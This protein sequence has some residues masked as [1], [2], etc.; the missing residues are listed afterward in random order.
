[1]R[2]TAK[3]WVELGFASNAEAFEALERDADSFY[4]MLTEVYKSGK[5]VPLPWKRYCQGEQDE[6]TA[7]QAV[8]NCLKSNSGRR[9]VPQ[10]NLSEFVSAEDQ[11]KIEDTKKKLARLQEV[12]LKAAKERKEKADAQK[13]ILEL[14]EA[15]GI[16]VKLE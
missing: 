10:I 12:A 13:R 2:F 8:R 15:A 1:M 16:K 11:K 7:R 14:A 9:G 5:E 4:K 3:S 6:K